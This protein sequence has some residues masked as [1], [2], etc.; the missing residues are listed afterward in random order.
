MKDKLSPELLDRIDEQIKAITNATDIQTTSAAYDEAMT[1]INKEN[2]KADKADI[3]EKAA[4]VT[5]E[6]D[7]NDKLAAET[8][9][10]LKQQIKNDSQKAKDKIDAVNAPKGDTSKKKEQI[11]K[12][13]D[14]AKAD[15]TSAGNAAKNESISSLRADANN[16]LAAKYQKAV[17]ELKEKFGENADTTNVDKAR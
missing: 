7:S 10:R 8:K 9:N 17:A 15:I 14:T 13:K 5:A 3:D 6:I 2:A 16:E 1:I 12:I 4:K 11:E